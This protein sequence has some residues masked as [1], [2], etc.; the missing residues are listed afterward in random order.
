[1]WPL[2][3]GQAGRNTM[4]I[5]SENEW[6]KENECDALNS[7]KSAQRKNKTIICIQK[8]WYTFL[9]GTPFIQ[10]KEHVYSLLVEFFRIS[11]KKEEKNE[12]I[13]MV[14]KTSLSHCHF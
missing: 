14:R 7:H 9:P 4:G 6:M 12:C 3:E 8:F 13:C 10:S 2:F 11:C 5:V 1:M